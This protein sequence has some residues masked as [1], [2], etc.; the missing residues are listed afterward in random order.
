M[1]TLGNISRIASLDCKHDFPNVGSRYP[2]NELVT[3]RRENVRLQTP[4]DGIGVTGRLAN[5]PP[6]PP[7][8]GY[9]L[10][11]IL[12]FALS[13]VRMPLFGIGFCLAFGHRINAGSPR[14][15][16]YEVAFQPFVESPK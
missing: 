5:R 9:I 4:P 2:V 14:L 1:L 15:A 3:K 13:A 12:S 11:A 16:R 8:A 10:K 6:I 7:F